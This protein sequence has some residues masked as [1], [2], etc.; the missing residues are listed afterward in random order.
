MPNRDFRP[1]KAWAGAKRIVAVIQGCQT[2][3][4][5]LSGLE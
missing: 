3:K 5:K 4:Q 2:V 1:L